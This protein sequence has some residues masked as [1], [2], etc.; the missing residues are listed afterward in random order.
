MLSR[1][2]HLPEA[3]A[4]FSILWMH[5]LGAS[6]NDFLPL[7]PHLD[8]PHTRFVFPHAPVRPVTINGALPCGPGTTSD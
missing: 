2:E 8:L 3:P 1:I 4:E 7:V 6:G 5:G